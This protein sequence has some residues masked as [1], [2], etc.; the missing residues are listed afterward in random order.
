[1]A[2]LFLDRIDEDMQP[3]KYND[4]SWQERKDIRNRYVGFQDGRCHYCKGPLASLPPAEVKEKKI[5]WAAFPPHFLKHPV[6]LHHSHETGLTI[7]A[8]HALCN[9]V[10]WQYHG[11]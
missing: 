9:A 2:A 7:G 10:L 6:H 11:E 8:V 4:L 3:E 5:R 1:M